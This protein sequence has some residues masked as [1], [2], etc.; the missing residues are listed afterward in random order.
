MKRLIYKVW[1][2]SMVG[3][4]AS[5]SEDDSVWKDEGAA[6]IKLHFTDGIVSA[7]SSRAEVDDTEKER[8]ISHLDVFF[9]DAIGSSPVI[10]EKITAPAVAG[11]DSEGTITLR[12]PLADFAGRLHNHVYV[13]A[14]A[15]N[16]LSGIQTLA[17]LQEQ[18]QE[19]NIIHVTGTSAQGAP[20]HFLMDGIASG[21]AISG[22]T[23]AGAVYVNHESIEDVEL[24][25]TMKRAAAKVLVTLNQTSTTAYKFLQD[26]NLNYV[27]GYYFRNMPYKTTLLEQ[28]ETKNG[29][30]VPVYPQ[31]NYLR[32][33]EKTKAGF[34]WG[35]NQ[36]IV[37]SYVYSHQ[38]G[39][40]EDNN[41]HSR[42]TS[43]VV[44][45][46]LWEDKN[47]NNVVDTDEAVYENSYYQIPIVDGDNLTDSDNSN[48]SW[49][50]DRNTLYTV[51]ATIDAPG[52][53]DNKQPQT[54]DN[55]KYN[56][57]E[58]K[59]APIHVG[60]EAHPKYLEVNKEKVEMH[61]VASDA[62]LE[63]TSSSL[64]QSVVISNVYY[65][66]KYGNKQT[67]SNLS[68]YG[69][70]ATFDNTVLAGSITIR[71]NV[72]TNFTA[73]YFT[74][75]ITNKDGA[76][77]TVEVVQ[78]PVISVSNILSWY[79][80][81]DDFVNG[82]NVA[83]TFQ[84]RY[85]NGR[86]NVSATTNNGKWTGLTYGTGSNNGFFASKVRGE[87]DSDNDGN[88][89]I[90]RYTGSSEYASEYQDDGNAR[91]YRIDINATS[92]DYVM[93]APR[94]TDGVTDSSW[95]NQRMVSPS[96]LIASRLAVI[97]TSAGNLGSLDD[98][99]KNGLNDC[100]VR[101]D[102]TRGTVVV[103]DASYSSWSGASYEDDAD[104]YNQANDE[105]LKVYADHCKKYV[106]VTTDGTVYKDWRLPTAAEIQF[107]ID[108]QGTGTNN[109]AIDYLL[110]A[111]FYYSACGPVY[112]TKPNSSGKTIRC[113]HDVIND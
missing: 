42:G 6:A 71:S 91:M 30:Q 84:N 19:D 66:D 72:P 55:L 90:Y 106:E 7:R 81:R 107:I 8:A 57:Q 93:G 48:D 32:I 54:L 58:W 95:P 100:G 46:P 102:K 98:G 15:K 68:S 99:E 9:F 47:G 76:T 97:S 23:P 5:C 108:T 110:N 49:R 44:N 50:I 28:F 79:S 101:F 38:W 74:L 51:T 40:V 17:Q 12:T 112:N 87:N 92:A 18:I 75:T 70:S 43:L 104:A 2:L 37:T 109:E 103:V 96:F 67:I 83:M 63:F 3:L 88:Y 35:T 33:P 82:A 10:H 41:Y 24:N 61:N 36:V 4:L 59:G 22:T 27:M 69:M 105:L 77:E 60:G 56:V 65:F 85:S 94:I 16:D 80:Y 111:L 39:N 14:N 31:G 113:V 21:P 62:T 78:Y 52:A 1:I 64:L 89:P 29:A 25:V 86:V 53:E 73:R 45:I 34:Q 26:A 13:V 11:Q 20:A